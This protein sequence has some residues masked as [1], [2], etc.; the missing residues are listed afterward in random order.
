MKKILV[1]GGA[2]FIGSHVV[3][4]LL[5]NNFSVRIIDNLSTGKID[6]INNDA[7]F[8]WGDVSD[9]KHL[10]KALD[11]IDSCIHLAAVA[12]VKKS[13]DDWAESSKTNAIGTAN[14]F[15]LAAKKNIETVIYASSAAVYGMPDAVPLS[16]DS[17]VLPLSPYGADKFL[18]E[19][20]AEAAFQC[21]NLCSIGLRFFN[22]Y[23]PRQDP[24]SP[25]S[26]VISQ[27]FDKIKKEE[28]L[29]IYGDGLQTRDFVYVVDVAKI[30]IAALMKKHEPNSSIFNVS[31]SIETNIN[32]LAELLYEILG[33]NKNIE[34]ESQRHGDIQKSCGSN[35]KLKQYF[36]FTSFTDLRTGLR[37]T[38][39]NSRE[40]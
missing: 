32:E 7:E 35:E 1:T 3:D 34:F 13:I 36:G 31:T 9:Q 5:K 26:G 10:S 12:S 23:G 27:F 8:M 22:I 39:S 21:F 17:K 16:E 29:K 33:K 28:P 20:Y 19:L 14:V 30:I 40:I 2:G 6:N 11:G 25:Y 15:E 37:S 18:N 38:I 24:S 4:L